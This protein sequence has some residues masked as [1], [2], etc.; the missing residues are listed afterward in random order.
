[1]KSIRREYRQ[2]NQA[3]PESIFPLL[4]PVREREWAVGWECEMI[5]SA[6]GV[7]EA[8]AVFITSRPEEPDTTWI[9]TL[10]DVASGRVEFATFTPENRVGRI[11]IQLT[12]KDEGESWVDIAYSYVA[13]SP[14]GERF[15]E[16]FSEVFF[17]G[18]MKG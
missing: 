8:G 13:L 15:I 14:Q 1:M 3:P 6:S 5:H 12:P 7:A 18:M 16:G 2:L 11:E 17:R 9:I 4:C 10:H